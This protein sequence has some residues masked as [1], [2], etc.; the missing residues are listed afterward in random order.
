ME[1]GGW[2]ETREGIQVTRPPHQGEDVNQRALG[3]TENHFLS[4]PLSLAFK[5]SFLDSQHNSERRPRS[6]TPD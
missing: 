5:L 2:R 6:Q 3:A 1:V 4:K